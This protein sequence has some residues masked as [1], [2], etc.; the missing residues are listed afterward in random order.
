MRQVT[1]LS[2]HPLCAKAALYSVLSLLTACGSSDE[3]TRS[4]PGERLNLNGSWASNC[5][6]AE[7]FKSL[8]Y[9]Y[10]IEIYTI[11]EDQSYT[12]E[13]LLYADEDCST[14]P[15]MTF[16]Y[17]GSYSERGK[18]V[19][20]DGAAAVKLSLSSRNPDWPEAIAS[21]RFQRLIRVQEDQFYFGSYQDSDTPHIDYSITYTRQQ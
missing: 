11:A 4:Y 7:E 8:D 21:I 20:D 17:I 3:L 13:K 2:R 19:A 10:L 14:E 18:V 12:Q 6:N 9:D 5:F 1:Q 16:N 15:V